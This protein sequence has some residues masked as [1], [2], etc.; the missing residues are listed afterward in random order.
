MKW[1]IQKMFNFYYGHFVYPFK[2]AD[3]EKNKLSEPQRQRYYE[4]I[5]NW[6]E[7]KA[8]QIEHQ[9]LVREFY[10]ELATKSLDKNQIT[11]YRLAL[12][13]IKNYEARL[14]LIA[15]EYKVLKI[16]QKR[17]QSLK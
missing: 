17:V 11:G 12:I 7:S 14:A 16:S 8:Y 2:R 13:F 4:D 3:A 10:Q 6:I 9:N 1:I 5:S 15:E